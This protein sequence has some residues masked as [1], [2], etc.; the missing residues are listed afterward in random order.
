MW[1]NKPLATLG[2]D[3]DFSL[4]KGSF[5]LAADLFSGEQLLLAVNFIW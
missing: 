4:E 1:L 3:F 2:K 5:F